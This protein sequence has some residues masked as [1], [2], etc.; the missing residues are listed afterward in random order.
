MDL[1]NEFLN[2]YNY[3]ANFLGGENYLLLPN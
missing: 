2:D 3:S 1:L